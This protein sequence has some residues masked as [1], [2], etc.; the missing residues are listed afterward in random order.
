LFGNI[1]LNHTSIVRLQGVVVGASLNVQADSF[2]TTGK[3]DA[4]KTRNGGVTITAPSGISLADYIYTV[5]PGAATGSVTLNASPTGDVTIKKVTT[6]GGNFSSSGAAF[7]A[8]DKIDVLTNVPGT[9]TLDHSGDII[10]NKK[11]EAASYSVTGGGNV[12]FAS[13][14]S[15]YLRTYMDAPATL[16]VMT[17]T[18]GVTFNAGST[19]IVDARGA[20]PAAP[21]TYSLL[22]TDGELIDHGFS[23]T[24]KGKTANIDSVMANLADDTID[25]NLIP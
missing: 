20:P 19:L 4:I 17:G 21:V 9:I 1:R 10:I 16:F 13:T 15:L 7:T 23:L 12:T 14:S 22:S 8:L 3:T 18:G 25:I 5:A 2:E 11:I 6:D 24:K